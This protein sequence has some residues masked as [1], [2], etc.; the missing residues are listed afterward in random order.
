MKDLNIKKIIT[1]LFLIISVVLEIAFASYLI[2]ALK[3]EDKQKEE[4]IV[5]KYTSKGNFDYKVYYK[6]NKFIKEEYI[7]PGEAYIMDLID[8]IDVDYFYDFSSTEKTKV[9]GKSILTASLV[10][11]YDDSTTEGGSELMRREL[12]NEK[13]DINFDESHFNHT[14]NLKIKLSEY[15]GI[16]EK[17]QEEVRT[18]V[19][20]YVVLNSKTTYDGNIG[21]ASY[22]G[23]YAY[24]MKI[25][26]NDSIL[27]I[28]L[29]KTKE[30]TQ[31]IYSGDLVKTNKVVLTFIVCAIVVL[32]IVICFLLRGLF[33]FTSGS[34]YKAEIDKLLKNY[35]DIIVNTNSIIDITKYKLIEISEFKEI[36]NLSREL[37]LPI[38]NYEIIKNKE[39]WFYVI[40]DDIF[41]RYVIT[42]KK[43]PNI[44]KEVK[45]EEKQ[46]D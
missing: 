14:G 42:D 30:D 17:F 15:K 40:K 25:P 13:I 23:D 43:V 7:K 12:V 44:E 41:Y 10:V 31:N 18:S 3:P 9:I 4:N 45:E 46:N 32:F 19:D 11:T 33:V 6:K 35:D 36:L 21:G 16:L 8:Y 5:M 38:M 39:T 20:G 27:K 22:D 24:T 26:L 2:T 29:A 1:I 37:L 28:D 34:T